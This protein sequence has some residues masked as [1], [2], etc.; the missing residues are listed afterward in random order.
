M[1]MSDYVG[2]VYEHLVEWD[3]VNRK[4]QDSADVSP[5]NKA[6]NS[7][8]NSG[9]NNVLAIRPADTTPAQKDTASLPVSGTD[10]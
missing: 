1:N 2:N 7:E 5:T 8:G 4:E 9:K 3:K 6:E 10:F